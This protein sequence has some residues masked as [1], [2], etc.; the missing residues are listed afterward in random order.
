MTDI[1]T[2]VLIIGT[3]LAGA[4]AA[5]AA[6]DAG[7]QV[8]IITKTADLLGGNTAQAQGGIVYKGIKDSPEKLKRDIV[9]AGAGHCWG[10][11]VDQLCQDGPRLVKEL[12]IDKL[13]V[14]FDRHNDGNLD[15]TEEGAHSEHRII[16]TRDKTGESIQSQITN[17]IESHKNITTLVQHTAVD[18]LTFSHHSM[19]ST[20]I[21]KKPACFGSIVL[22]SVTGEVFPIFANRTI[23][24]TGGLGSIYLHTSN[25]VEARG[26][27]IAM[28]WRAGVRC[29]NLQYIQ[30]HPTSLFNKTDRFLISESLRGE[31]AK[32]VNDSGVEFMKNFHKL[33]SLAPRDIVARGIHQTMLE[34]AHPCVYLDISYKNQNWIK[35]RFPQIYSVCLERGIDITSQPIPVVPSAH[36]SCGGLSVNLDGHT[37][38]KR[39]YAVGE[40]SC[41]GVHG[42]NRL[43][44]TSLLEALVWGYRAGRD[45]AKFRQGDDWTPDIQPWIS[46]DQI[47]D[48][49]LIS[50]DW[51]TIRN[52]MWNYVG[53][54]RTRDRLHRAKTTLRNLQLDVEQFYRNARLDDTIV[55]LRNGLQTAIAITDSTIEAKES[56]GAHF[57][58]D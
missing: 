50:Q 20:D 52:T 16:H 10:A 53:L 29:I 46:E 31:G 49:A 35:E 21:Y 2:E 30:F 51:Q 56:L 32:L 48:T 38:L 23:L 19:I 57:V 36:Y 41:T 45:A 33:G 11:A 12:L 26:D 7:R 58:V 39:L 17:A 43:A 24:A 54:V 14:P 25:P 44:S 9:S 6:A 47:V 8:T 4:M 15:F 18:L 22:N 55:G 40:V 28:A 37:S 27:G 3:G 1:K 34:T 13:H 5:L 42:A